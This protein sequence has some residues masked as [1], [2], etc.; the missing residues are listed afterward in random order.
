MKNFLVIA[1]SLLTLFAYGCKQTIDEPSVDPIAETDVVLEINDVEL[2]SEDG[3]VEEDVDVSVEIVE[4]GANEVRGELKDE[5]MFFKAYGKDFKFL[6]ND[7]ENPDII[8]KEGDTVTV[9]IKSNDDM[10]HDFVVDEFGAK[11]NTV[12]GGALT[13]VTFVADKKGTFKYFCSV[14]NHRAQGME[15]N[16]IVE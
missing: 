12:S 6:I 2:E 14:G 11:S 10:P 4:L 13:S 8:V 7:Q 15:G 9:Q 5:E 16:L 3:E 1:L